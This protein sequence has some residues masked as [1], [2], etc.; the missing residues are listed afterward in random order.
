MWLQSASI[1][2]PSTGMAVIRDATELKV[3]S[4]HDS[5]RCSSPWGWR[6]DCSGATSPFSG[7]L[8]ASKVWVIWHHGQGRR[9]VGWRSGAP[10]PPHPS[11]G[12]TK[13]PSS[14]WRTPRIR[15]SLNKTA[16]LSTMPRWLGTGFQQP[17]WLLGEGGV[18]HLGLLSVGVGGGMWEDHQQVDPQHLWGLKTTVVD[19]FAA[20]PRAEMTRAWSR[21]RS[22]IVAVIEGEG[23]LI[24]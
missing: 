5:I 19:G 22:R 2:N 24:E 1:A 10:W 4:S 11:K 3:L 16:S 15:K 6:P 9:L 17:A 23:D 13:S 14:R 20:M 21:Y 12:L 8:L 7:R 18:R